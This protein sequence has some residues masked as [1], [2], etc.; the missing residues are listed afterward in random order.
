VWNHDAPPHDQSHR[1]DLEELLPRDALFVAADHVVGDA[2]V[3]AEDHRRHQ[4]EHLLLLGAEG[5]RFVGAGVEREEAVDGQIAR[6]E[7]DVVHPRPEGVEIV[8]RTAHGV[9]RFVAGGI[10]C[11][12]TIVW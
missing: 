11:S 6:A 3:A 8:D 7:D 4:A 10:F 5:A 12:T 1:E 9:G 2:V